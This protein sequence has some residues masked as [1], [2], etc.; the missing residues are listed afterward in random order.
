MQKFRETI[1]NVK[2]LFLTSKSSCHFAVIFP[3]KKYNWINRLVVCGNYKLF[4]K[5][6]MSVHAEEHALNKMNK[7]NAIN[8]GL[9]KID[10]L[11]LKYYSDGSLGNSKPCRNCLNR[12]KFVNNHTDILIKNIY[13]SNVL[14]DIVLEKFLK[15]LV[16]SVYVSS[17]HKTKGWDRSVNDKVNT[18]NGII[19]DFNRIKL[20]KLKMKNSKCKKINNK[21]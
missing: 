16:S 19:N 4:G 14:G 18:N 15:I 6:A 8:N 2:S 7:I 12:F 9:L 21:K 13:Y 10:I 3:H 17:G 1:L 11:V 5:G 20:W